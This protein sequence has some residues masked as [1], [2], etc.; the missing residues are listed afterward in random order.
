MAEP[1]FLLDSNICIYLL[2]GL[3]KPARDRIESFEPGEVVT[4]S[5]A[6]AEV[7]RGIDPMNAKAVADTEALFR[8]VD[9]LPFDRAAAEAYLSIP[10]RRASFDRLIAAHA[11][12]LGLIF[13][14]NNECDFASVSGLR[15][16]N[17]TK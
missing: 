9:V 10:F 5:V 1:A 17:W 16:E 8:V 3:S 12:S 2:E 15:V 13:V 6:Y 14:T 7:R 4:S 11:L